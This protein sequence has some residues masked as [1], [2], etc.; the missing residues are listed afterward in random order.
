MVQNFENSHFAYLN[1][2]FILE[3][4]IIGSPIPKMM[5]GD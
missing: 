4:L 5:N 2:D 3:L 1:N